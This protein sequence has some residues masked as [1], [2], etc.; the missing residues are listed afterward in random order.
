MLGRYNQLVSVRLYP[1]YGELDD[2]EYRKE[3]LGSFQ[4]IHRTLN[5]LLVGDR[6][7]GM[8]PLAD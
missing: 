6:I 4:S 3:R 2:R 7:S 5:H 8:R 1:L